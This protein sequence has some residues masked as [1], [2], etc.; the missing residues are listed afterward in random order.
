MWQLNLDAHVECNFQ[1]SHHLLWNKA[2]LLRQQHQNTQCLQLGSD[3]QTNSKDRLQL[4]APAFEQNKNLILCL[5]G[6]LGS[7]EDPIFMLGRSWHT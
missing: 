1:S 6:D 5:K 7:S 3:F 2:E 4:D